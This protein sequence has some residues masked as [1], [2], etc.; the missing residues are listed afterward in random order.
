M[1]VLH[2][3]YTNDAAVKASCLAWAQTQIDYM[4]GL[5]G[6]DRWVGGRNGCVQGAE[7]RR[8]GAPCLLWSGCASQM[9]H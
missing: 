5:K 9:L 1:M 6:S 4:L 7:A 2:A 3:K 8:G